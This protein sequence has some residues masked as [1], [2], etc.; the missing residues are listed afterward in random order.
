MQQSRNT[1]GH[2]KH[3]KS[4]TPGH[5]ADSLQTARVLNE[6]ADRKKRLKESKK[7]KMY[8]SI[9]ELFQNEKK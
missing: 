4:G 2:S 3:R 9:R 7:S 8:K 5:N 1:M 6:E